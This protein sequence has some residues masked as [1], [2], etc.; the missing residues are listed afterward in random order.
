M[1]GSGIGSALCP[2]SLTPGQA[3]FSL[4][5]N[6]SFFLSSYFYDS[7]EGKVAIEYF[8]L[9]DAELQKKKYAF[10]AHRR[11]AAA[12]GAEGG[13][14]VAAE[15][16]FAVNALDVHPVYGTLASGGSDGTFCTWDYE[17]M[18][19]LAQKEGFEPGVSAL[20]FSRDGARVAIASSY[21]FDQGADKENLMQAPCGV[22]VVPVAEA[23]VRPKKKKAA[24]A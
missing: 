1:Q 24:A 4:F 14:G 12:A 22:A 15:T 6:T 21:T 11:A 10:K 2:L 20:A 23:E 13:G 19:R 16:V 5:V 17:N 18:K 3:P 8:D 9:S 7:L